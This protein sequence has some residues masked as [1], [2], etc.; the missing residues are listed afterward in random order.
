[1]GEIRRVA[2]IGAKGG[3][4][5]TTVTANL[6]A[7]LAADRTVGVLDLDSGKGDLAALLDLTPAATVPSLL[8]APF[9]AALLR[10]AAARHHTGFSV[11]AQPDELAL[12]ARP[13]PAEAIGLINVAVEA[14]ALV[15]LDCG[16][17][18][19]ETMVAV[20]R[21]VDL[22]VIVATPELLALRDVVRLRSLLKTLGVPEDHQ[23]LVINRAN[24]STA[25]PVADV[26]E[27]MHV[28][29]TAT[30]HDD[31]AN[32]ERAIADGRL[33]REVA[34][35]AAITH[36]LEQL[37]SRILGEQPPTRRKWR[38]P[39]AGVDV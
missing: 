35:G 29:V 31:A 14:W 20:L 34:P 15:L 13:L 11:I 4:G 37:W 32:C 18:M 16:A 24:Q 25:F 8:A 9:D 30:I 6:A 33:L 5:T 12:L 22:V 10:G 23:H 3:C 17:R 21:H 26:E 7:T 28:P 27:L 39:W 19:D 1:M 36:D 38:L 2:L